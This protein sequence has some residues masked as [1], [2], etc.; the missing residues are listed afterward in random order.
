[1]I[2]SHSD[3][4][5]FK[6]KEE[7]EIKVEEQYVKL[8]VEKYGGMILSTWL[9]RPLSL[10]GRVVAADGEDIVIKNLAVDK[11]LFVIPNVAIHMSRDMNKGVEYNA[12]TDMLP[13][14]AYW[15]SVPG[16]R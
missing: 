14:Y 1:M 9:D 15:H 2:A 5:C 13:L 11:D 12:Q 3:S 16:N 4:P 6:I 10:A 8:N 7:P